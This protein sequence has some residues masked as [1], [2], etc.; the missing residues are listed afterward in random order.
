MVPYSIVGLIF[1]C[2][3]GMAGSARA[4]PPRIQARAGGADLRR[5]QGVTKDEAR[6][7]A[8]HLAIELDRTEQFNPVR[9]PHFLDHFR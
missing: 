8:D 7:L 9:F 5:G 6:I 3:S 1:A 4:Q 2:V